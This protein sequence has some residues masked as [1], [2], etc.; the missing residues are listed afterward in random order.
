M[1]FWTVFSPQEPA[2]TVESLAMMHDRPA[3]DA[4]DPGD[5]AVGAVALVLPVGEQPV[6]DEGVGV[7]QPRHALAHGHLALLERLLVVVLRA[8]GARALDR[9][10]EILHRL[11]LLLG[12]GAPVYDHRGV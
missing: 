6:L 3:A 10:L 5:D 2:F 4:A 12:R 8:P 9:A 11:L 7:E 1:I